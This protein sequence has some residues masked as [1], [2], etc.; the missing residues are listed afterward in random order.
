VTTTSPKAPQR[1]ALTKLRAE[2]VSAAAI[3]RLLAATRV[4]LVE[5]AACTFLF[6]GH[7]DGVAVEHAVSGLPAPLQLKRLRRSDLW[8]ASIELPAGSRVE[9]RL[10]V[11]HGDRIENILDPL[12]PEIATGPVGTTSVLRAQG[13]ET[14]SWA[15]ADPSAV[16]GEL[17]D[18]DLHSRALRRDAHL[19]LYTPARMRRDDRLPLLIVHDGGD[20]LAHASFAAVLDNL[21]DQRRMADCVVAFTHPGDRLKEYGASAAHSR[22]LTAELVPLLEQRFPLRADPAGRVLAGA[23]FG[24]IAALT[25]AVRAP[26]FYGGLLL[27]S[28]S[29]LYTVVGHEH[30]GGPVFDPV[31][32]FVNA[33]RAQPPAVVEQIFLSYGAFEPSAQRNLAMVDVLRRMADEVRVVESLDGHTWTGWRDRLADGLSWLFPGE[34]R[35]LYP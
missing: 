8:Y 1:R 23:S 19:T 12:N 32:R 28:A 30:P 11:R 22:F 34:Q 10:L 25:A 16:P 29:F 13:Y 24:A 6:R 33:I 15:L 26:G 7:A 17:T 27:Q 18:I 21:M 31:V 14:P 9:Y 2:G 20:Y 4:P 35:F 3:D 5:G